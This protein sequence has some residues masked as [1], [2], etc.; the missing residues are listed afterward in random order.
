MTPLCRCGREKAQHK[1]RPANSYSTY[2]VLCSAYDP[3]DFSPFERE[4]SGEDG[5]GCHCDLCTQLKYAANRRGLAWVPPANALHNA[6]LSGT[7]VHVS[8]TEWTEKLRANRDGDDGPSCYRDYE[9]VRSYMQSGTGLG[10]TPGG[11]TGSTHRKET[12]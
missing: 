9:A 8:W 3:M 7:H 1:P 10:M 5:M 11:I 4:L 12:S 2:P 6:L